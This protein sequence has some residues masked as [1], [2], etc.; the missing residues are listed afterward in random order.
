MKFQLLNSILLLQLPSGIGNN[1]LSW[2]PAARLLGQFS[3][4]Q[5]NQQVV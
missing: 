5:T 3:L 2:A 1:G 4:V